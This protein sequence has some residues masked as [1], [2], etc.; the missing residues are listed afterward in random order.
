MVQ[1]SGQPYETP[2]M[3]KFFACSA[4]GQPHPSYHWLKNSTTLDTPLMVIGTLILTNVG[5]ADEGVYR[6]VVRHQHG[7]LVSKAARVR[8]ACEFVVV[9]FVVFFSII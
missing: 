2:G 9:V 8:V 3:K 7:A 6:C 4:A 1:P 5:K